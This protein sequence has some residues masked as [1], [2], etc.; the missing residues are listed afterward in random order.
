MFIFQTMYPAP[1]S[2]HTVETQNQTYADCLFDVA[3]AQTAK[4]YLSRFGQGWY[5][6]HFTATEKHAQEIVKTARQRAGLSEANNE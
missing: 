4:P 2:Q 6:V 1:T 5:A 3:L